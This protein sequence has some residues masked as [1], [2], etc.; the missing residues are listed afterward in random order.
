MGK[1]GKFNLAI[2]GRIA[3]QT[4]KIKNTQNKSTYKYYTNMQQKIQKPDIFVKKEDFT[5]S[6]TKESLEKAIKA[7]IAKFSI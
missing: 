3:A 6:V 5:K 2:A 4:Q 7:R 1:N